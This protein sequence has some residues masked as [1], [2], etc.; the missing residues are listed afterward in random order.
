MQRAGRCSVPP[1][2]YPSILSTPAYPIY[3]AA[4]AVQSQRVPAASVYAQLAFGPA[5][6]L[7][8]DSPSRRMNAFAAGFT[9]FPLV[10]LAAVIR[11][12]VP[13]SFA[14]EVA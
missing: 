1:G 13:A 12:H 5:R 2:G 3:L 11:C 10:V 14:P 9:D 8:L 4:L 7:A 6:G